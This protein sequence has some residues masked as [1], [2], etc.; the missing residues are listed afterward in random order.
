M[1]HAGHT[2]ARISRTHSRQ[3][4][5]PHQLHVNTHKPLARTHKCRSQPNYRLTSLHCARGT[6]IGH[7]DDQAPHA[8]AG[9]FMINAPSA[10]AHD[11]TRVTARATWHPSAATRRRPIAA[12][13]RIPPIPRA[14]LRQT[15]P[16][17]HRRRRVP[18]H[19]MHPPLTIC[20]EGARRARRRRLACWRGVASHALSASYGVSY[21][22]RLADMLSPCWLLP[23]SL[24]PGRHSLDRHDHSRVWPPWPLSPVTRRDQAPTSTSMRS[25]AGPPPA[26][27]PS[28]PG[29]SAPPS[30]GSSGGSLELA[31]SGGS[32]AIIPAS[33]TSASPALP[34]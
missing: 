20:A 7:D 17:A 2:S 16:R 33:S 8:P 11:L 10:T 19:H 30:V 9:M 15:S 27:G 12:P 5:E 29:A 32:Q 3:F 34:P 25:S 23:W 1:A 26:A 4:S 22:C 21:S 31:G 14:H 13:P 24:P 28:P 6:H 18:P